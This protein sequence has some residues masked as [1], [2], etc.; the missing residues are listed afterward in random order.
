MISTLRDFKRSTVAYKY[1]KNKIKC[2]GKY[3]FQDLQ[4]LPYRDNYVVI[5]FVFVY[6][7]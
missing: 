1:F 2:I 4:L 5:F 6:Y 3:I 7:V